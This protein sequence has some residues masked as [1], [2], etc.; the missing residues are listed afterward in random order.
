V[1]KGK[2]YNRAC[3]ADP[4]PSQNYTFACKYKNTKILRN[5]EILQSLYSASDGL[6]KQG[7]KSLTPILISNLV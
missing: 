2:G 7:A 5:D 3:A 4:M 1:G 6:L